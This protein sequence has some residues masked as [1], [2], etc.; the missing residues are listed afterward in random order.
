MPDRGEWTS[1]QKAQYQV[2]FDAYMAGEFTEFRAA[3]RF[4]RAKQ[5]FKATTIVPELI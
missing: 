2:A 3:L 5:L 4:A 1:E